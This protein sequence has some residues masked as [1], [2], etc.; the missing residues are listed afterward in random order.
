MKPEDFTV[1]ELIVLYVI[2]YNHIAKNIEM[3]DSRDYGGNTR[4]ELIENNIFCNAL[5]KKISQH[6]RSQGVDPDKLIK[7]GY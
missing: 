7:K 2:V 3:L 5:K 1:N 6:L 4:N